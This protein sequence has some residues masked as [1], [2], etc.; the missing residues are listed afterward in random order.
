VDRKFVSNF[1]DSINSDI[2]SLTSFVQVERYHRFWLDD[3]G[4][5]RAI[6]VTPQ[7]PSGH[8]EWRDLLQAKEADV[9]RNGR[10]VSFSSYIP[11]TFFAF[12]L[13]AR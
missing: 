7:Q 3:R 11:L 1:Q 8:P 2:A 13:T 6:I 10:R 4:S 5:L 12:I 9:S